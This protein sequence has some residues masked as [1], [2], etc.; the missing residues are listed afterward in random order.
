[1]SRWSATKKAKVDLNQPEVTKRLREFG[2]S[3]ELLHTLGG[4]VPDL[5]LGVGGWNFLIELK[6]SAKGKLTKDELEW[7]STWGG[8]VD[9]AIT[10]E[11]ILNIIVLK[12]KTASNEDIGTWSEVR[13]LSRILEQERA[14]AND[15]LSGIDIE[16]GDNR[17]AEGSGEV[18]RVPPTGRRIKRNRGASQ[19]S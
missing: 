1:M 13:R 19:I 10:V 9:Q 11:A 3:V 4:G 15:P 18:N 6:S 2:I 12:L 17:R 8:Q 16:A 14:K 7:H 5:L